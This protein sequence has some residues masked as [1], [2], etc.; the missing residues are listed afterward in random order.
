[1]SWYHQLATMSRA[2]LHP[3]PT[4]S[5]CSGS[6]HPAALPLLVAPAASGTSQLTP[7]PAHALHVGASA[8][9]PQP[10]ALP[11]LQSFTDGTVVLGNLP[12]MSDHGAHYIAIGPDQKVNAV[13]TMPKVGRLGMLIAGRLG[14]CPALGGLRFRVHMGLIHCTRAELS[15]Q[16]CCTA[17]F[18]CC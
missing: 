9:T 8:W 1:M 2:S 11:L 18:V 17:A 14:H 15:T 10:Q 4:S 7:S 12:P 13:H 5:C 16:E 6:V 3:L